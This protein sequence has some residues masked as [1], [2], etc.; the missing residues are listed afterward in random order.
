MM[1]GCALFGRHLLAILGVENL[2]MMGGGLIIGY[3]VF[4]LFLLNSLKYLGN[5]TIGAFL[6]FGMVGVMIAH[7]IY[8]VSPPEIDSRTDLHRGI[9]KPRYSLLDGLITTVIFSW[10]VVIALTYLPLGALAT[11]P[12]YR[13]PD[14]YDLPKHLFTMH[15]L[16]NAN[17]WP[18][19]NPFFTGEFFS[20]N[21]LF[22]Y[23]PVLAVSSFLCKIFIGQFF[24]ERQILTHFSYRA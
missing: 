11:D 13:L 21:F 18:P 20:Y 8:R 15:S 3:S 12:Q 24:E 17:D 2:S 19:P 4:G 23:P 7:R 16:F 22:Y 10:V 6:F 9:D 5:P 14:I 1:L